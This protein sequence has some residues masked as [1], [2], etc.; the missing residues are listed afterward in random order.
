M[1]NDD[2]GLGELEEFGRFLSERSNIF[3][4]IRVFTDVLLV[5]I[6]HDSGFIRVRDES[7]RA[8]ES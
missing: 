1:P 3:R 6:C 7:Q 5:A 8:T 4:N 2:E